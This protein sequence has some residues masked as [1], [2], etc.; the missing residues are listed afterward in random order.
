MAYTKKNNE[1]V[2]KTKTTEKSVEETTK[3]APGIPPK[4]EKTY[5]EPKAD[6]MIPC[7]SVTKGELILVGKKTKEG[8]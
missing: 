3:R 7:R 6:D 8:T 1:N 2:D 5:T 4:T